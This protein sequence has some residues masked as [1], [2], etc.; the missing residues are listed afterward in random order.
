MMYTFWKETLDNPQVIGDFVWTAIDYIGE[1]GGGEVSF[2]GKPPHGAPFPYHLSGIGDFNICGFKR[3]QS[4][5]RDLLWG[6]R[7][8]PF[9]AVLDPQHHGKPLGFSP[10][11][12]EP[13]LDTWTFPGKE[14]A[15]TQVDVY[16]IDDEVE[17]IV[18]GISAGRKPAGA[19][20]QNKVSFDVEYQPGILEAVGYKDG[21]EKF[22]ILRA[23]GRKTPNPPS[24]LPSTG[25]AN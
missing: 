8:A 13:V 16:S 9:I 1:A 3:V 25:Q 10:W 4:Y 24:P 6:M 2:D 7:T 20:C 17:V 11:A 21:Q 15:L 12:W 19:A 14:G 18:N 5:Y 23:I 22:R